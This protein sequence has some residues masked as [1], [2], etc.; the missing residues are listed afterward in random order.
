M[1]NTTNT[2]RKYSLVTELFGRRKQPVKSSAKSRP[3]ENLN[4]EKH[5][6]QERKQFSYYMQLIDHDTQEL[7]GHLA[8]IS[9]GGF[10]AGQPGSDTA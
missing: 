10:Q 4:R 5:N 2:S 3:A 8:D 9:T 1:N 7:V 6:R